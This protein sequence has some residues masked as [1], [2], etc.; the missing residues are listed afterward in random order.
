MIQA[1]GDMAAQIAPEQAAK[2]AARVANDPFL[3]PARSLNP[4]ERVVLAA[5]A[6]ILLGAAYHGF[7]RNG[8]SVLWGLSWAFGAALCPTVTAAF[9]VSQGFGERRG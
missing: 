7:R 6:A 3:S 5:H 4:P 2:A 8:D 9:A 1:L